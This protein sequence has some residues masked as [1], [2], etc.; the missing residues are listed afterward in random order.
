[1]T[2]IAREATVLAHPL[3]IPVDGR[4]RYSMTRDMAHV[5]A[6]LIRNMDHDEPFAV[7]FRAVAQAMLSREGA[8]HTQV[9]SLVERGW[10]LSVGNR[11]KFVEPIM[12]FK[13]PR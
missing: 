8:V 7:N 1:M 12:R 13:A 5:Y 9:K 4:E 10:L 6:W 2:A 11:Y 3:G